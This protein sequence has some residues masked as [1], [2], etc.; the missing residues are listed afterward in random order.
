MET[1]P[2]TTGLWSSVRAEL[3]QTFPAEVF[4]TWFANLEPRCDGDDTLILE[5]PNEFAS[6]WL[7]DNYLDLIREK[8]RNRAGSEVDVVFAAAEEDVRGNPPEV[9]PHAVS[10]FARE[11]L[12]LDRGGRMHRSGS[13]PLANNSLD[14]RRV[15]S[16]T[17]PLALGRVS[18]CR[19]TTQNTASV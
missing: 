6:I 3:A 14:S 5:A 13:S 19:S 17:S 8:V 15:P 9:E 16:S 4:R 11:R 1:T 7:E 12:D 18:A 10:R 2:V